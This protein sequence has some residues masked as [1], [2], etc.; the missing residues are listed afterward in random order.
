LIVTNDY[1]Y[2]DDRI[3]NVNFRA[4]FAVSQVVYTLSSYYYSFS[5]S[6]SFFFLLSAC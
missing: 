4:V 6:S 3:M 1:D 5:S 2:D